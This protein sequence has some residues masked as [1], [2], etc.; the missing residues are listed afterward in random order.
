[1]REA[2]CL[3]FFYRSKGDKSAMDFTKI[4]VT[5]KVNPLTDMVVDMI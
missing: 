1:M 3:S 5:K 4:V 2:K